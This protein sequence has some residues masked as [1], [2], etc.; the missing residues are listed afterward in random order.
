[1]T[2]VLATTNE[3]FWSFPTDH[4]L[5]VLNAKVLAALATFQANSAIATAGR[6][7][8]HALN[9]ASSRNRRRGLKNSTP[10]MDLQGSVLG[11]IFSKLTD[12]CASAKCAWDAIFRDPEDQE[13][14]FDPV[15][16]SPTSGH[17]MPGKAK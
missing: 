6:S 5:A 8:L 4:M 14:D 7:S 17:L 2:A 15:N 12:I 16:R 9:R 11:I 1:M 13:G 3:R 10:T